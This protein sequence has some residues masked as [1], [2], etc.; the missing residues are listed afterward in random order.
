MCGSVGAVMRLWVRREKPGRMAVRVAMYA[1]KQRRRAG[2]E[3]G[4]RFAGKAVLVL[5]AVLRFRLGESDAVPAWS[6]TRV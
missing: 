5:N 2:C 6:I 1:I 4:A 3:F